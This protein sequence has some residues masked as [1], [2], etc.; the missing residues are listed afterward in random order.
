MLQLQ[1]QS[2]NHLTPSVAISTNLDEINTIFS[3]TGSFST[4]LWK[5]LKERQNDIAKA[6]SQFHKK[7]TIIAIDFK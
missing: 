4:K 2:I 5:W 3:K 7:T 6:D 1:C